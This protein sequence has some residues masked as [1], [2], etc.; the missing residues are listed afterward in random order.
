MKNI[1]TFGRKPAQRNYTQM[2][3]ERVAALAA[4][5]S[6]TTTR[7]FPYP[8]QAINMHPGEESKLRQ[9]LDAT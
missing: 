1:Y 7:R 3:T 8:E 2:H 9:A 6:E 4:F 5:Q